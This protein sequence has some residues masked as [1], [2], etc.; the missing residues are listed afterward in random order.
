MFTSKFRITLVLSLIVCTLPWLGF[1]IWNSLPFD[2]RVSSSDLR[3]AF[4]GL[5]GIIIGGDKTILVSFWFGV[6]YECLPKVFTDVS[7]LKIILVNN[8]YKR[9]YFYP[10][11]CHKK[12]T[13]FVFFWKKEQTF[14][15][16]SDWKKIN[17]G[18]NSSTSNRSKRKSVH[19]TNP[20]LRNKDT[21][22]V[23][24]PILR[25][26]TLRLVLKAE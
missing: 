3:Y 2:F 10:N 5:M 11:W 25:H 20:P 15:C 6:F 16:S 13:F 26:S 22:L 18:V 1:T 9:I 17:L 8:F 12:M 23:R 7:K 19:K 4:Y 24:G 14:L 21:H